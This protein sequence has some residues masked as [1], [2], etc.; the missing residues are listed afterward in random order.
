MIVKSFTVNPFQ[1][2]TYICHDGLE[3]V[4][5]D[6]GY[7]TVFERQEAIDYITENN[8]TVTQLL[9][10]H[11]HIDHIIDCKYWADSTG[12]SF[13]LHKADAPLLLNAQQQAMMFGVRM[14]EAPAPGR[15]LNDGDSI[16]F[17]DTRWE[18]RHT[19][20]H[21][22]GS[23]CFID[24]QGGYVI[25]GDVLFAGSIGRTDLWGGSMTE[26]LHS[27]R[28]VL[29]PLPDDTIVYSGHGPETTIGRERATNPFLRET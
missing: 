13:A 21:S 15:I 4:I 3:A 18:V 28:T 12:L 20:G 11:A 25:G 23:V 5:I 2:N 9:L 14:D 26:L 22:P 16:D 27:I 24:L 8:L 17:G 7:A 6:P 19:P 10:T 29:L 1:E